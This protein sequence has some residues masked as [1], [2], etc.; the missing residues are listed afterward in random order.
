VGSSF[1]QVAPCP[2]DVPAWLDFYPE[3]A[4]W[5]YVARLVIAG[6]SVG[7]G[8]PELLAAVA[9]GTA[10]DAERRLVAHVLAE[11]GRVLRID[12]ARLDGETPFTALGLDS[13]MGLELRHRLQATCGL[14]LPATT[15]WTFPTPQALGTHLAR[16][17]CERAPGAAEVR[18][19]PVAAPSLDLAQLDLAQIEVAVD[20]ENEVGAQLMAEL[21]RL[22]GRVR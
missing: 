4:G 20:A 5:P 16:T 13:L 22:E 8:D 17:L 1:T 6:G 3:L 18:P 15:V 9:A 19:P 7:G 10:A 21:A 14:R 2:I 12:P 11:T